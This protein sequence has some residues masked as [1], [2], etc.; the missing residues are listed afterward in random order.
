MIVNPPSVILHVSNLKKESCDYE[1]IHS[2]FSK[3][4][5]VLKI[6]FILMFNC[7]NMALVKFS[8]L[9][10]A[11]NAMSELHNYIL[12]GRKIMISFTKSKI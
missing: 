11:I 10:E 12:N 8:T 1:I 4:G 5:T 2:L 3:F 9:S 7:R 6:S